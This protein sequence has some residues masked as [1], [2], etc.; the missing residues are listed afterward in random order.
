MKNSLFRAWA[1]GAAAV[2]MTS[3][4]GGGGTTTSAAVGGGGAAGVGPG[5]GSAPSPAPPSELPPAPFGLTANTPFLVTGF[6]YVSVESQPAVFAAIEDKGSL[7]WSADLKTYA[8]TTDLGSGRLAYTFPGNNPLAFSLI[9]ADGT[10][11]DV[12]VTVRL[13]TAAIGEVFWQSADGIKPFVY[14][15][16][17]FGIPPGA[18]GIPASGRRVFVTDA[19]SQSA[20]VFDFSARQVSGNVVTVNDN[21]WDPAGPKEVATLEPATL[22]ADGSFVARFAVAGTAIPGE[23]RGRLMGAEGNELAVYWNGPARL[24]YADSAFDP[25]RTVMYYA[26]CSSCS[27]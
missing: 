13:H 1:L 3:A 8:M 9:R 18:G 22:N 6:H 20:L 5:T 14:A 23:L 21:G 4:C 2:A 24:G 26:A 11:A 17:L 12:Y 7:A 19:A 25:H 27:A 16:G 15:R 10:K